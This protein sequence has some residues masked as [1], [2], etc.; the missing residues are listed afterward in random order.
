MKGEDAHSLDCEVCTVLIKHLSVSI[1]G[2]R[3]SCCCKQAT[4]S[5]KHDVVYV[6]FSGNRMPSYSSLASAH[7]VFWL[8]GFHMVY[9]MQQWQVFSYQY[10]YF[11]GMCTWMICLFYSFGRYL[12]CL[13]IVFQKC[14]G[15]SQNIERRN[16]TWPSDLF[17]RTFLHESYVYTECVSSS[18]HLKC[19]SNNIANTYFSLL[20]V[21]PNMESYLLLCQYSCSSVCFIFM[22]NSS[23]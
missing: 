12:L 2:Y 13:C 10:F 14:P 18:P 21:S 1:A 22:C 6:G 5:M 16:R 15:F 4:I 20:R 3:C 19:R 9:P 23:H 17:L 8:V 11:V 7:S